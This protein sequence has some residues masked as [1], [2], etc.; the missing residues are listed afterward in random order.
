MSRKEIMTI[1]N[2]ERA[3]LARL[4]EHGGKIH[5]SI[6]DLAADVGL[7]TPLEAL[8]F[9]VGTSREVDPVSGLFPPFNYRMHTAKIEAR[10][11]G[12]TWADLAMAMG[13]GD[14]TKAVERVRARFKYNDAQLQALRAEATG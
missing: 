3:T 2:E 13:E 12:A 9:V 14:D 8:A 5:T 11:D 7:N 1:T 10:A 6:H 4:R